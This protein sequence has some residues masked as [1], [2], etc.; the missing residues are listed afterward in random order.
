MKMIRIVK[1]SVAFSGDNVSAT[2]EYD[3]GGAV[4]TLSVEGKIEQVMK[5]TG[6]QLKAFV[7]GKVALARQ[8]RGRA[9]AQSV[10]EAV[11]DVD[12]EAQ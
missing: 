11:A 7:L 4:Y 5:M 12:L 6:A 2:V 10:L 9:V 3:F 1:N 8:A